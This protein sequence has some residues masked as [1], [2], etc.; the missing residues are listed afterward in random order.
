MGPKMAGDV[1]TVEA[2]V[3]GEDLSKTMSMEVVSS[4]STQGYDRHVLNTG[5]ASPQKQ[6]LDFEVRLKDIDEEIN[7]KP[8]ISKLN[9]QNPVHSLAIKDGNFYPTRGYPTRP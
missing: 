1:I 2:E 7:S 4:S 5:I 9:V 3:H 6:I 8:E